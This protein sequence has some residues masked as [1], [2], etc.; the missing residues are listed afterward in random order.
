M[1]NLTKAEHSLIAIKN[2]LFCLTEDAKKFGGYVT[3]LTRFRGNWNGKTYQ[4]RLLLD[5]HKGGC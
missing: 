3:V 5:A 2:R 4:S 1:K